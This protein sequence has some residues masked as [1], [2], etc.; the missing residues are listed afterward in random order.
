MYN[1]DIC[2]FNE[3]NRRS[4]NFSESPRTKYLHGF[5]EFPVSAHLLRQQAV[6]RIKRYPQQSFVQRGR[7]AVRV[8]S[9]PR[10]AIES[11]STGFMISI[12]SSS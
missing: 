8:G 2:V 7:A 1:L 6:S 10:V 11:L 3:C 4:Q 9:Q 5:A 12:R